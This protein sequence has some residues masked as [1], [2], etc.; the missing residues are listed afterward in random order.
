MKQI[1]RRIYVNSSLNGKINQKEIIMGK[2]EH[3]RNEIDHMHRKK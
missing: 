2:L 1:W 3:K